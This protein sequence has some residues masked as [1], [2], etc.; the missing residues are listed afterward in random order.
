MNYH[1]Y[2]VIWMGR[3]CGF[4]IFTSWMTTTFLILVSFHQLITCS[5]ITLSW[6][7][8]SLLPWNLIY[9]QKLWKWNHLTTSMT[10]RSNLVNL[11]KIEINFHHSQNISVINRRVDT[12]V[13]Q[14]WPDD[15]TCKPFDGMKITV[16]TIR[17]F[18]IPVLVSFNGN[19]L[20]S[21]NILLTTQLR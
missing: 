10:C 21:D 16:S 2:M 4:K 13:P 20:S 9:G 12:A 5:I 1:D 11:V 6:W 14:N 3:F 8:A 18:Q 19:D 17:L 7:I 15:P